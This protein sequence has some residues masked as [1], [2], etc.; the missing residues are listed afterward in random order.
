MKLSIIAAVSDNGVIGSG[1]DIPWNVKGE[2]LLFKALTYNQW[3]L[4]GRK[5]FDSMGKLPNRKYAVVSRSKLR[6]EDPDICFYLNTDDALKELREK[7]DHVFVAGGGQV[8]KS[9]MPLVTTVHLSRI[10]KEIQG[11]VFFPDLPPD[12]DKVFEQCFESNINYIYQIW[13]KK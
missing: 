2:Q 6:S 5:T 11:D 13:K 12:F 10:Q 1:L 7:T 4:I 3:L 9:M 8:Y